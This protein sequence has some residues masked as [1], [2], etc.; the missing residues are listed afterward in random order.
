MLS[1][2]LSSVNDHRRPLRKAPSTNVANVRSLAH[3]RQQM[4]PLSAQGAKGLVANRAYV[5]LSASVDPHVL[6]QSVLTGE[7]FVTMVASVLVLVKL[8][9]IVEVLL[10]HVT[11][12]TDGTLKLFDLDRVLVLCVIIERKFARTGNTTDVAHAGPHI[13]DLSV[14][15]DLRVGLEH[16]AA[17]VATEIVFR[18]V[19]SDVVCF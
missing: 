6:N 4:Y 11:P 9:V 13:V 15:L 16:F 18:R 14:G 3:V 19:P 17:L 5:G 7:F 1:R 8:R 10:G 12:V 2:M